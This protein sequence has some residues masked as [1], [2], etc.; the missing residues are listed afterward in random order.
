MKKYSSIIVD[1]EAHARATLRIDLEEHCPEIEVLAQASSAEEARKLIE[2]KDPDILFLDIL[3]PG[4]TGLELL[5]QYPDRKFYP[6]IVSSHSEYAIQAIREAAFDF[7]L[8]PVDPD[9]LKACMNRFIKLSATP[10]S[11]E[12]VAEP[13]RSRLEFREMKETRYVDLTDILYFRAHGSYTEI[14]TTSEQFTVSKNL[15]RFEELLPE[16]KFFRINHN[17]IVNLLE[18][19]RFIHEGHYA[20]LKNGDHLVVSIRK[21]DQFLQRMRMI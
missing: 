9:E 11:E 3:M 7:L 13:L 8:K 6:V 16:D 15:K 17:L 20:L 10:V 14:V 5:A 1:D 4:G 18:V 2:A 19:D 12:P 21:K